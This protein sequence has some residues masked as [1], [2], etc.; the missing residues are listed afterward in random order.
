MFCFDVHAYMLL[1]LML[2]LD[3]VK[4]VNKK[5]HM[6][7]C[8][9]TRNIADLLAMICLVHALGL[10]CL[11]MSTFGDLLHVLLHDFD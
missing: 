3:D 1:A 6:E 4:L 11:F 9:W 10:A 8:H 5:Y 7:L 2:E